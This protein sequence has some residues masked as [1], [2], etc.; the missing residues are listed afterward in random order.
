MHQRCCLDDKKHIWLVKWPT[1]A[2]PDGVV[3]SHGPAWDNW[4]EISLKMKRVAGQPCWV[5]CKVTW[6]CWCGLCAGNPQGPGQVLVMGWWVGPGDW[7][8]CRSVQWL[9]RWQADA[10]SNANEDHVPKPRRRWNWLELLSYTCSWLRPAST[11]CPSVL[12][13]L[14]STHRWPL[15]V[16]RSL[17]AHFLH[18]VCLCWF[19]TVSLPSLFCVEEICSVT[20]S[21][22]KS[23][24]A[25][26]LQKFFNSSKPFVQVILCSTA[27]MAVKHKKIRQCLQHITRWLLRILSSQNYTVFQKC[28]LSCYIFKRLTNVAQYQ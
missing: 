27:Q 3:L 13:D 23:L 25:Q 9:K 12:T 15:D 20:A 1:L 26:I 22:T 18:R 14:L 24:V 16:L 6:R 4:R 21:T 10:A 7:V 11:A 17:A 5:T 19:L 8:M 28:G 2:I